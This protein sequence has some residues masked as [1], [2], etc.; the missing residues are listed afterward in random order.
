MSFQFDGNRLKLDK[1]FHVNFELPIKCAIEI[2][3][4]IVVVLNVPPRQMM[5]ENMFG[6]SQI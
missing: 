4:I 6:V 5:T 2:S 3:G 1:G